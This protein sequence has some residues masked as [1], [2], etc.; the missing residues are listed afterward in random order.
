MYR[1]HVLEKEM[2]DLPS[3]VLKWDSIV[4]HVSR[5]DNIATQSIKMCQTQ[6]LEK[7]MTGLPSNIFKCYSIECHDARLGQHCL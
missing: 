3:R 5:N 1:K 2:R 4:C 6:S 7:D